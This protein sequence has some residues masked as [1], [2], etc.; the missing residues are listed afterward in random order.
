[1]IHLA[2]NYFC[3]LV[4]MLRSIDIL[5]TVAIFQ[6]IIFY[7]CEKGCCEIYFFRNFSCWKLNEINNVRKKRYSTW[8]LTSIFL[9]FWSQINITSSNTTENEYEKFKRLYRNNKNQTVIKFY[10]TFFFNCLKYIIY[11]TKARFEWKS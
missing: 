9:N 3:D 11:K 2:R 10:L 5:L 1:M 6:D 8:K 7:F 4:F